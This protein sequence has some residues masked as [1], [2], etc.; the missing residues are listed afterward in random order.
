MNSYIYFSP[1]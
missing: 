1:K